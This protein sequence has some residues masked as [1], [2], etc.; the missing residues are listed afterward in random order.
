MTEMNV[1]TD[2]LILKARERKG[3]TLAEALVAVIILLLVSAVVAAGVPAAAKAYEN[4]IIASNAEVIRSTT[5]A[6]LRNELVT[7]RDITNPDDNTLQFFNEAYGSIS[8][9]KLTNDG[10]M[11]TRYAKDGL[12]IT[13]DNATTSARVIVSDKDLYPYS[14]KVT[15]DDETGL[16][17]FENLVVKRKKGNKNE[18]T[19]KTPFSVKTIVEQTSEANQ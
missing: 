4:V 14:S 16:V 8:E 19:E 7:A 6:E 12:V 5:M 15:Y 17:T 2:A 1:K 11:F 13:G 10:I 3:F 9:I 18:V